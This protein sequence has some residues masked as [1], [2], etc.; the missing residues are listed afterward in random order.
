MIFLFH[1]VP[2]SLSFMQHV[3]VITR[4]RL[5]RAAGSTS[6]LWVRALSL[7]RAFRAEE[8]VQICCTICQIWFLLADN[9]VPCDF[10]FSGTWHSWDPQGLSENFPCEWQYLLTFESLKQDWKMCLKLKYC[11]PHL[12]IKLL[13]MA[14]SPLNTR[15][16]FQSEVKLCL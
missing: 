10:L 6:T 9:Y 2:V 12:F 1:S 16:Y 3:K 14:N 8:P 4:Y 15:V 13:I 7:Q 11:Y 5:C